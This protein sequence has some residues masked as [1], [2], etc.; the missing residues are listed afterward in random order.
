LTGGTE[1]EGR[2]ATSGPDRLALA[3]GDALAWLFVVGVAITVYEVV[4][5]YAFG[6]PTTWVHE[7]TTALCAIAFCAGGAY[8]M[9]R[10]EHVRI[11]SLYDR[12]PPR[13]QRVS[14]VAGLACGVVY[15]AGLGYAAWLQMWEAVW[16]FEGG[17]WAPEPVPGPP[18]WPLPAIVRTALAASV[19]LFL[20]LVVVRL[21]RR[22][23]AES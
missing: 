7:T 13:W 12:F 15:L 21:L 16:H 3:I 17:H 6:S 1:A 8:A 18:H 10:G 4:A 2:P 11:T 9:A 5:R 23:P 14:T 22:R 19:L 20:V